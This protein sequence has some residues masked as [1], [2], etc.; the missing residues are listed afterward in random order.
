VAQ[1]CRP[2][3][4]PYVISD[5]I[6]TILIDFSPVWSRTGSRAS[7][8]LAKLSA[9][10]V[11]SALRCRWLAGIPDRILDHRNPYPENRSAMGGFGGNRTV[12]G[13]DTGRSTAGGCP[14]AEDGI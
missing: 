12:M 14:S 1:K 4:N 10:L 3:R 2:L 5:F 7:S 9:H 8:R 6:D 13:L 11:E